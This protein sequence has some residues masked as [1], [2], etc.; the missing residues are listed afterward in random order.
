[1]LSCRQRSGGSLLVLAKLH[2]GL[3]IMKPQSIA[4]PLQ[5]PASACQD[6]LDF[7]TP[8]VLPWMR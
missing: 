3:L 1:M 2:H 4:G 6:G 7:H 5:H 8:A